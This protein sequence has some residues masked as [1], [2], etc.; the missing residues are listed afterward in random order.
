MSVSARF[1]AR[2]AWSFWT[3]AVILVVLFLLLL[4]IGGQPADS[5]DLEG[6]GG[7]LLRVIYPLT[8]VLL[9]TLGALI[10]TRHPQNWI[11]WL[12][13]AWGLLFALE[14]FAAAY[15]TASVLATPGSLPPGGVW[16]AWLATMLNVHIALI[17]P[18]LLLFPDGHLA[19][20][21]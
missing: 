15:A 3:L 21:R 13:C 20:R 2:L 4:G 8:V 10:A 17:V 19:G 9:A 7:V 11:G 12:C 6:V 16:M 1:D 14:L 5:P 18:V